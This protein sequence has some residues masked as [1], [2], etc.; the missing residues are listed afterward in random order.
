MTEKLKTLFR[1]GFFHIFG[2]RALNMCINFLSSIVLVRILTKAEYGVFTHAWNIYSIAL[3]FNGMGMEFGVLHLCSDFYED[4]KKANAVG[5][6]ATRF[7]VGFDLLIGAVLL[8]IGLFIPLPIKGSGALLCLLCLLP[9]CN[10]LFSLIINRLR[11]MRNNQVFSYLTSLNT[12]A[13]FLLSV[14]CAFLFREKGLVMGYY[15]AFLLAVAVGLFVFKVPLLARNAS[16]LERQTRR[17]LLS[18]SAISMCNNGLSHLLYYLDIFVL[19]HV[20]PEETVLASYKVATIIPN[21]LNTVPVVLVMYLYPYFIAHRGDGAWCLKRYKQLLLGFGAFNLAVAVGLFL[22]AP[23]LVPFLFGGQYTD[24][25][26]IFRLLSL[27]Y[28]L[29]GT[30][31]VLAGNLLAA[32]RKL[33]YNLLVAIICGVTNILA[34]VLF[35][36]WWGSMGAALATVLVVLVSGVMNTTYLVYTYRKWKKTPPTPAEEPHS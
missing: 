6:F 23:W 17:E 2:S 32:A 9:L 31:R 27:N 19:G 20:I 18:I 25:V 35:I 26:T 7:G 36:R 1:T 12:A 15:L 4:P 14:S 21:A 13:L 16:P 28:F 34:D 24:A 11:A 3:I 8:A 22:L 10:L 30:F 5:N 33:K 29:S